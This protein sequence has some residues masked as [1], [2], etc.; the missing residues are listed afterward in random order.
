MVDELL[1]TF[2]QMLFAQYDEILASDRTPKEKL[3]SVVRASFA[4]IDRHHSEVAIFQNDAAFLAG[5]D[6]FGYLTER[7]DRFERLWTDLL[8]EAVAAGELRPISTSTSSTAS[9]DT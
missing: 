1:D 9:S 7:N 8:R 5:F 4:A 3:D 2:Q 6:R